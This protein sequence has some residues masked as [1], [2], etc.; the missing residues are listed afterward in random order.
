MKNRK[1]HSTERPCK[2]CGRIVENADSE[3]ASVTCF[4]CVARLLSPGAVFSDEL[5]PEEFNRVFLKK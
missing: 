3:A 1:G 4:R 5:S 2:T